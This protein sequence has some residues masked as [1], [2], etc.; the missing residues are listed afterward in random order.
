MAHQ[1]IDVGVKNGTTTV[2]EDRVRISIEKKE[3]VVWKTDQDQPF[4]LCFPEGGPFESPIF[5]GTKAK[6]A[7]SEH[8]VKGSHGKDHKYV[9][10]VLGARELDPVVHTDP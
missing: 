9:V 8:V 4:A 3:H 5:I 10:R 6:P 7:V 2:S 1:L